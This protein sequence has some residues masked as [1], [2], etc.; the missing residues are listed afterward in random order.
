MK[1]YAILFTAFLMMVSYLVMPAAAQTGE[2]CKGKQ[3]SL[4]VGAGMRSVTDDLYKD[5]YEDAGMTYYID[6]GVKVFK[7]LEVFVHTDIFKQ[8]GLTTFTKEDTTFKMFPIE[9]GFRYLVEGKNPCKQKFVPYIGAGAGYYN[10]KEENPI[11][12]INENKFGF[13]AEGGLRF[14][15]ISSV[16]I[17][18]KGKYIFL[19]VDDTDLGGFAY[20]GGIGVSF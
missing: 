6:L 7:S 20:M 13:F 15:L 18:A 14:Y 16:F 11:D 1:K 5:V 4:T 12:N 8:D 2:P 3:F 17:D 9:L 19:K 10:Y